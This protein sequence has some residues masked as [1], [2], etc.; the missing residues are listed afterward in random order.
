M[1]RLHPILV[2]VTAQTLLVE[3]HTLLPTPKTVLCGYSRR[4][5]GSLSGVVYPATEITLDP[6]GQVTFVSDGVVEATNAKGELFGFER[7]REMSGKSA[8]EIV[9]ASKARC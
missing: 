3:Q 7:T 1:P 2:L 6:R 4:P 5:V 8:L 9:A